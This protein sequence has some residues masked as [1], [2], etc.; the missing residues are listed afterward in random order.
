MPLGRTA[1]AIK[2]KTD[3]GGLRAVNCACCNPC[4]PFGCNYTKV[5]N[6]GLI[7]LLNSATS[8]SLNYSQGTDSAPTWISLGPDY[9]EAEWYCG[10]GP[11]GPENCELDWDYVW[12]MYWFGSQR[13]DCFKNMLYIYA[14]D[15]P[16]GYSLIPEIDYDNCPGFDCDPPVYSSISINGYQLPVTMSFGCGDPPFPIYPMS[17]TLT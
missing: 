5:T 3:N 4:P 2:I 15:F 16:W 7:S 8:G 1:N 13:N 17:I 9:F 14:Y 10:N 12:Q 6:T 11:L